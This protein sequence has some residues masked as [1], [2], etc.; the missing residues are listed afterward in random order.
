MTKEFER[1]EKEKAKEE[2]KKKKKIEWK[3]PRWSG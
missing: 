1:I 3:D 2:A